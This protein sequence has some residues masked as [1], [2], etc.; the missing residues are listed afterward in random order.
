MFY[1]VLMIIGGF[2]IKTPWTHV[3]IEFLI[4]ALKW[5]NWSWLDIIKFMCRLYWAI[6]QS[7]DHDRIA[8]DLHY[9]DDI[10]SVYFWIIDMD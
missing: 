8:N 1:E 2:N 7:K 9:D 5:V 6:E 4:L 3:F 10:Y